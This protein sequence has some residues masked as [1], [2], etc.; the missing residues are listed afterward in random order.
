TF[1]DYIII[2]TRHE[3]EFKKGHFANSINL[4][5]ELQFETWLGSIIAPKEKFYLIAES[6]NELQSLIERIAKIGYEG[7]LE[8]AFVAKD[9]KGNSNEKINVEEF[10]NTKKDYTIVDIRNLS[11]VKDE[12]IFENS[13]HIPLSELRERVNEIPTD[14]PIVVHCAGGYRSAAGISIIKGNIKT[15]VPVF[16]LSEAV[17]TF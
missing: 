6:K 12:K 3:S 14:K 1:E 17:T 13:I 7:Q 2:D 8:K 5:N 9:I 15:S 11:E 16:D 10:R 4:M